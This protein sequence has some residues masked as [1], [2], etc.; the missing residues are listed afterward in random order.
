MVWTLAGR[1]FEW[2]GRN[3]ARRELRH[4]G[5]LR[6]EACRSYSRF[7]ALLVGPSCSVFEVPSRASDILPL[8]FRAIAQPRHDNGA[9][10]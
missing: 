6:L 10:S 7:V 9:D 2:A 5:V 4:E 1:A 3:M 8:P